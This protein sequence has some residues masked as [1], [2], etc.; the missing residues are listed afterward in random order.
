MTSARIVSCTPSLRDENPRLSLALADLGVEHGVEH[1]VDGGL[2]EI[3]PVVEVQTQAGQLKV[4]PHPAG[5]RRGYADLRR[6][7]TRE[8]IGCSPR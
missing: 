5:T 8:P 7:A 4:V 2:L 1:R 3:E 6:A